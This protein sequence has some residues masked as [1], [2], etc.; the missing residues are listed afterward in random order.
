MAVIGG[1]Q[2]L[3]K[4]EGAFSVAFIVGF[5][6]ALMR[7]G[8]VRFGDILAPPELPPSLFLGLFLAW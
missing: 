3:M 1:I 5:I 6:G 2:S 8:Y 4:F 7:I